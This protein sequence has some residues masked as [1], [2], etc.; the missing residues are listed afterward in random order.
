[1]AKTRRINKSKRAKKSSRSRHQRGGFLQAFISNFDKT[2]NETT[3]KLSKAF[4]VPQTGEPSSRSNVRPTMDTMREKSC[5]ERVK[6]ADKDAVEAKNA[7]DK[8]VAAAKAMEMKVKDTEERLR[9][10]QE[11]LT[12]TKARETEQRKGRQMVEAEATRLRNR[13]H[14]NQYTKGGKRKK[15]KKHKSRKHKSRKRRR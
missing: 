11:E 6:K 2:I 5:E 15:S 1:M 4:G 3:G 12:Q 13:I 9:D 8:A 14:G 10:I 7:A